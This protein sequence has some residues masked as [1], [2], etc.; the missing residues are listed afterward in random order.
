[1][2]ADLPDPLSP[3]GWRAVLMALESADRFGHS[4]SGGQRLVWAV[5]DTGQLGPAATTAPAVPRESE[6]DEDPAAAGNV[7]GLAESPRS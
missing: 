6:P 5:I 7:R 2:E 3:V 1:M 4:G